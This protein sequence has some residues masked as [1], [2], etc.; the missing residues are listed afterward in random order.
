[1]KFVKFVLLAVSL[2]NFDAIHAS[3][4]NYKHPIP[5]SYTPEPVEPKPTGPV[6]CIACV[7]CVDCEKNPEMAI[8]CPIFCMA[9]VECV[10][11]EKNPEMA[12]HCPST[13]KRYKRPNPKPYVPKPF[14]P[15]PIIRPIPIKPVNCI[16]CIDCVD[17]DANPNKR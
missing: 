11:C 1:M 5:E 10:D 3:P 12:I 14:N 17:C 13:C 6:F 4:I 7:E 16:Q 9:C 15:E 2:L 8:H